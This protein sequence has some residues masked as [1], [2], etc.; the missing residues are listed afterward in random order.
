MCRDMK[1]TALPYTAGIEDNE[2]WTFQK[3]IIETI[4]C[5]RKFQK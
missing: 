3:N 2:N 5:L 1:V 4:E